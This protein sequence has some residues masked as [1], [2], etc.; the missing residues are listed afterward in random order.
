MYWHIDEKTSIKCY[1]PIGVFGNCIGQCSIDVTAKSAK[2]EKYEKFNVQ[3]ENYSNLL[4][5]LWL[6]SK[7]VLYTLEFKWFASVIK[8][9]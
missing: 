1:Q 2:V 4:R 8:I 7:F 5:V 9:R 6:K 3:Y